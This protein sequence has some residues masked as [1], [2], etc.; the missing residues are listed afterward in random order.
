MIEFILLFALRDGVHDKGFDAI[1][2]G[3]SKQE[4]IAVFGR[5]SLG[6]RPDLAGP[7]ASAPLAKEGEFW[8]SPQWKIWIRFNAQGRVDGMMIQGRSSVNVP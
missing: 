6:R 3:M 2:F 1:R 4:V 5:P 8:H 7:L